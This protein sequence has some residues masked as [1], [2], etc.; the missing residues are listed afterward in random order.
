MALP[1]IGNQL[2]LTMLQER[3]AGTFA[4]VYLAEARGSDGLSRIVAV[5]V[6]KEQ[7]L[8]SEDLIRRTRDEALLL[9]RLRHKNILRVEAMTQIDGNPAIVM[10]F[11]DGVD[12]SQLIESKDGAITAF[13]PRA[14]YRIALDTA[15]ALHA[16]WSRVPYGLQEA[17][18]V[19]HRDVKPPN[20]MVSVEGEVKV[21]D[22]G[23]AR[24]T[25]DLR[26]AKTGV[27]RFGSMKYM[28]PERRNGA[29]GE[30]SCDVYSLGLVLIE[31]LQGEMLPL[32][33]IDPH[34]HDDAM[35]RI[36]ADLENL[37]LPDAA[38]EDSL[39][40]ALACMCA[41]S[42][43]DRLSAEQVIDL[44]RAFSDSASGESLDTFA[45]RRVSQ[46]AGQVYGRSDQGTLSGSQVFV[47]LE[48]L[49]GGI[50]AIEA[51]DIAPAPSEPMD[52][53]GPVA[54]SIPASAHPSEPDQH[55][56]P[57]PQDE[58]LPP[59][60][61]ASVPP[62]HT[63][64]GQAADS[65]SPQDGTREKRHPIVWLTLILLPVFLIGAIGVGVMAKKYFDEKKSKSRSSQDDDDDSR[66]EASADDGDDGEAAPA[67][68]DEVPIK[69]TVRT[70]QSKEHAIHY[71]AI[72]HFDSDVSP[73]RLGPADLSEPTFELVVNTLLVPG[74]VELTIKLRRAKLST[75]L[76]VDGPSEFDCKPSSKKRAQIDCTDLDGQVIQLLEER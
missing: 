42:P 64:Q 17:L 40:K 18:R 37:S 19:V 65:L 75:T 67:A 30:H 71:I 6:L 28:S 3:S 72:D 27:M 23:T 43:E 29:R 11:V 10:E 9:A 39:R 1:P 5:K 62:P 46:V 2:V 4:K 12:L 56:S 69:F 59:S 22:F 20:I 55:S 16:A 15:S 66:S 68:S 63:L 58:S 52:W 45:S 74:D 53:T 48:G 57:A 13:P 61:A 8:E 35:A 44:M 7:W 32:L 41:S 26:A 14:A 36:I 51:P 25:H 73:R 34:E 24:F 76:T 21:L 49:G 47:Q 38:W 70:Q 50:A 60:A 54:D 33:P 31:M